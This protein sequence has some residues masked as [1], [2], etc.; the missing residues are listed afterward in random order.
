MKNSLL[1]TSPRGLLRASSTALMVGL[2]ALAMTPAMPMM[3]TQ[4]AQAQPMQRFLRIGLNKATIVRLPRNAADVLVGNPGIADIVIRSKRTAYIFARKNGQTN[5]YFLDAA[6]NQILGLD[7]E[8]SRDSKSLQKL[9]SR[10]LPGS[11]ISVDV[12]GDK[13]ILRG[14]AR[15]AGEAKK[16]LQLAAQFANV[17]ADK[18][19]N[20]LTI[21]GKDQV[22]IK[23]KIAEVQRDVAKQLGV[24]WDKVITAGSITTQVLMANP[25]SLGQSLGSGVT[26]NITPLANLGLAGPGIGATTASGKTAGV[27]RAMERDGLMRLLA[28]PT[29]TAVSGEPAK[30]LAG[31]EVPVVTSYDPDSHTYAYTM[32]PF[33]VALGFTPMVLSEGRIS[34]KLNTEVSEI[35]NKY[36]MPVGELS[37][38]GFE[39]RSTTTTVELPSGGTLVIGGLIREQTKQ[40]IDGVPA[41]KNLP[42]L[43]ALFRSRDFQ[44]NNTEL[45]IMVTPYIVKPVNEKKLRTPLDRL[46]IASDQQTLFLGRLHRV[47]GA[48]SGPK[49]QGMTYHGNV[50]FI[51]E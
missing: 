32:K 17:K 22:T 48:P 47:Y 16:A 41:L 45:V 38:P 1:N 25:F 13:V 11:K 14:T 39:K 15:T 8:V 30:F 44:S 36:S 40:N 51:V 23:V 37:V 5:A 50:G 12:I 24:N 28:E 49:G 27:L 21:A 10:T 31:G 19:V 35:S 3:H 29:L 7:I 46:N 2:G 43:G 26:S 18:I 9:F 20:T 33:G 4:A 34:L 42:V 6:G